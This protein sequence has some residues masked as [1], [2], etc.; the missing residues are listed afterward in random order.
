MALNRKGQLEDCR[1]ALRRSPIFEGV[2]EKAL[3]ELEG[4]ALCHDYPKNNIL[5]YEGDPGRAL[6]LV[7]RGE[8]KISLNNEE[9]REVVVAIV[10]PGGIVGLVSMLD[11]GPQ[12][13]NA[14]TVTPSRLA[15]FNGDDFSSWMRRHGVSQAPL[16]LELGRCVRQA[17]QKI[18]EHALLS[19]KERLLSALLEIAEREG[20][21]ERD[22][23]SIVFTRP[24][25]QELADRIGS[26][27]EVVSRV[28]KELLESELLEAEGKVIRVSESALV[29]REE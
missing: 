25:H 13:A 3:V 26:S 22:G 4:M 28:L 7:V 8:V 21:P 9:G 10:G 14:S 19:V 17:Y 1:N 29:L 27:R 23:A 2:P 12:P 15:R 5:F 11:G 20:E 18:G 24:T 16:L 6:F